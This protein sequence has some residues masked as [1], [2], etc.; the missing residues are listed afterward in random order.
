MLKSDVLVD[1]QKQ[2]TDKLRNSTG[3]V[4]PEK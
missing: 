4:A 3:T 1:R 2:M